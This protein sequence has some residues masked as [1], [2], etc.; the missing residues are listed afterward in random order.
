MGYHL[1]SKKLHY[2]LPV[3]DIPYRK[4]VVRIIIKNRVLSGHEL[5]KC[6]HC[7][8]T[9]HFA[10]ACRV[11]QEEESRNLPRQIAAA[12]TEVFPQQQYQNQPATNR[13]YQPAYHA[14]RGRQSISNN[15][16]NT[17]TDSHTTQSN[18]IPASQKPCRRYN[19]NI[20]CAKPPCQFHHACSA[21]GL[22]NHNLTTCYRASST[23]FIPT[24][25]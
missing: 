7:K 16:N 24:S 12:I 18:N 5:S 22:A 6:E 15:H 11:K 4:G 14:F 25:K 17:T 2:P 13:P 19:A 1:F 23:N 3:V 8:G 20:P 9:G 21:C 10:S